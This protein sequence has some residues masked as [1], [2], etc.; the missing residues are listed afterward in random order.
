MSPA[1]ILKRLRRKRTFYQIL[2]V[3]PH[4]EQEE[5]DAAYA[6]ATAR[7]NTASLP[8]VKEDVNEMYL[9]R[10]GYQILSDPTQ[11]A[12]YDA[13]LA[14]LKLAL[15]PKNK[16]S[17]HK[18][19]VLTV[20]F[21]V[22]TTIFGAIVYTK[23]THKI[24]EV[25]IENVQAAKRLKE[26]QSRPAAAETPSPDTADAKAADKGTKTPKGEQ[27]RRDTTDAARSDTADAKADDK[28]R[29]RQ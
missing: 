1:R 25:R 11:R 8:G 21:A 5:I 16:E 22:L 19:G 4:A 17:L 14:G 6:A 24:E 13:K 20:I 23:L 2:G 9:V 3:K 29:K 26:A 7:L 15:Y 27:S 10:E 12:I 28:E 18:L